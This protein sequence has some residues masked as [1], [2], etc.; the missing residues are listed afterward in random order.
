MAQIWRL[1]VAALESLSETNENRSD[2][3]IGSDYRPK[4]SPKRVGESDGV[5]RVMLARGITRLQQPKADDR[6]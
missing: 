3:A 2:H 6:K 4:N 1:M 5:I